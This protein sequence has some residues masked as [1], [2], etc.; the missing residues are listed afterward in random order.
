MNKQVISNVLA[1]VMGAGVGVAASA[2][3]MKKHYE[4]ISKK[5]I[6]SV[7]EIYAKKKEMDEDTINRKVFEKLIENNYYS[8]ESDERVEK[9]VNTEDDNAT[10]KPYLIRRHE[11]GDTDYI[12]I[13]LWYWTDGIVTND[14]KKIIGNVEELI[15]DDFMAHFGDDEDDPDTVYVRNDVQ[16]IDYEIL[17]EYRGFS[18]YLEEQDE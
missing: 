17:K 5:E 18:D 13:T 12:T 4:E 7:K 16:K 9:Q 1:F 11:V 14:N 3:I 15:G 6:E 10:D 2:F 8:T